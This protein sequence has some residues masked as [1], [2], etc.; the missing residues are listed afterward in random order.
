MGRPCKQDKA[1]IIS[2]SLPPDMI[3]WIDYRRG[4][5]TRSHFVR[6]AIRLTSKGASVNKNDK[7][8]LLLQLMR[9]V[10]D[11]ERETNL[12]DPSIF[13]LE[14]VKHYEEMKEEVKE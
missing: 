14:L 13:Y 3:R 8:A 6:K 10:S 4:L 7:K 1:Q 2:I 11:E 5:D 12:G 9:H